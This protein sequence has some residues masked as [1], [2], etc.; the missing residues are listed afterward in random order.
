VTIGRHVVDLAD[1][2]FFVVPAKHRGRR[3]IALIGAWLAA[4]ARKSVQRAR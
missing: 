2:Y 3:N 4:E 1:A